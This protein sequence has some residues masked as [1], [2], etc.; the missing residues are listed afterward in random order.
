MKKISWVTASIVLLVGTGC[1]ESDSSAPANTGGSGGSNTGGAG[2]GGTGAG[3]S[4]GGTAG[5]SGD[6]GNGA[7]GAGGGGSVGCSF[8]HTDTG[9]LKGGVLFC[10]T[11]TPQCALVPQENAGTCGSGKLDFTVAAGTN[12]GTVKTV[13]NGPWKVAAAT[14]GSVDGLGLTAIMIP[15]DVQH[16]ITLEHSG[17]QYDLVLTFDMKSGDITIASFGTK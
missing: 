11:L 2:A 13:A 7:A 9:G 6:G 8:P 12:G 4:S 10:D 17:T 5:T 16:T 14:G 3:G 1:G 15:F